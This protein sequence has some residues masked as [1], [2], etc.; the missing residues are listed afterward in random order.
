MTTVTVYLVLAQLHAR[1]I[2]CDGCRVVL[3][4]LWVSLKLA[5]PHIALLLC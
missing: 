4:L 3:V 2:R 1:R 5:D